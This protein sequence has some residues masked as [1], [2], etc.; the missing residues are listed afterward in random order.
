L[1]QQ[2]Y[3]KLRHRLFNFVSE[4]HK[5][6]NTKEELEKKKQRVQLT[7][8]YQ[9][10]SKRNFNEKLQKILSPYLNAHIQ[11][12]INKK[13]KIILTTKQQYSLNALLSRQKPFH[14]LL[15]KENRIF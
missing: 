4:Q 13:I 3:N 2:V 10:G 14:P 11:S 6:Y 7:Y 12:A 5:F 1:D 8:L 15:N 9:Y